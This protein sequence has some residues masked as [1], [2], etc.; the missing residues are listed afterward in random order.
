[1]LREVDEV[2][3]LEY[4]LSNH[5]PNA[6]ASSY[7]SGC[8]HPRVLHSLSVLLICRANK[9]IIA[10]VCFCRQRLFASGLVIA[11]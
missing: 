2:L 10:D 5:K 11:C 7:G 6:R 8:P 9:M 3:L 1:M 4:G